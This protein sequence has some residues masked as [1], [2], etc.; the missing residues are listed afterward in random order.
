MDTPTTF[1]LAPGTALGLCDAAGRELVV[2]SGRLWLTCD[3]GA[4]DV[5]LTAGDRLRLGPGAVIECDSPGAARLQ[6]MPAHGRAW[7]AAA[8][9]WRAFARLALRLQGVHTGLPPRLV[10]RRG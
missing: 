3:G 9:A 8:T 1:D 7:W 4:Q 10:D 2:Y 5:F 6:L